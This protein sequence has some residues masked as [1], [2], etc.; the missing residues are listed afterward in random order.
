MTMRGRRTITGGRAG[1][2]QSLYMATLSAWRC[3]PT[4][5]RFA[6][7]LRKAGKPIGAP[8]QFQQ[9]KTVVKQ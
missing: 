7:R 5:R 9:G 8:E 2:R 1:V 4:I 3:N 6:E